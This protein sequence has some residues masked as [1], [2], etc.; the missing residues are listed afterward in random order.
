MRP[1]RLLAWPLVL[2]ALLLVQPGPAAPSGEDL[3]VRIDAG[4]AASLA[5]DLRDGLTAIAGLR[6]SWLLVLSETKAKRLAEAGVGYE[7][8][9]SRPAGKAYFLVRLRTAEDWAVLPSLGRAVRLEEGTALFWSGDREA[10]EIL[11]S[12]MQIARLFLDAGR[13]LSRPAEPVAP[14]AAPSDDDPLIS[15]LV[16]QVSQSRIVQTISDLEGFRTRYASTAGCESAGSYLYSEF[17]KLGLAVEYDDFPFAGHNGRNVVATL[18]GTLFPNRQVIVCGHYDS[19]SDVP[20]TLAPGADDNASG[21]AGVLEIAHVLAGTPLDFTVKFVCFSAEEWGLYGSKHYAN[22]AA[23]AQQDIVAVINMDMI[24]YPDRVPHQFDIICNEL[25]Y[26]LAGSYRDNA[27][28]YAGLKANVMLF[29]YWP[30]SDHSPFWDAGYEAVCVIENE[31]PLN[32]NYHTT[33][34]TLSTLN[35][36][37]ATLAVKASLATTMDIARPVETLAAPSGVIIRTQFVRSLYLWTKTV[38]L[39]W[40]PNAEGVVGYHVYR[41]TTRGGPYDQLT[42]SPLEGTE[43]T[44]RGLDRSV[45]YYYVV[46]A[47]DAQGRESR[48]SIEV[49]DKDATWN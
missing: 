18:P 26:Y 34:D 31:D 40:N 44:D 43:Y 32:P 10:R 28:Q 49:S 33:N 3:L 47:L 42:T 48:P 16:A 36:G 39:R 38:G 6:S 23:I 14:V 41:S 9:D 15:S 8:L 4:E 30:Y 20:S 5:S 1:T 35:T 46:T 22:E 2:A 13:P 27:L 45:T 12:R 37:Y 24:A 17:A 25:S 29:G 11:P 21:T 7:V 19:T